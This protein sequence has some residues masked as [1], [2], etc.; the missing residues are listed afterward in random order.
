MP[1]AE[2]DD[3]DARL[4]TLLQEARRDAL[5]QDFEQAMIELARIEGWAV[6][7]MAVARAMQDMERR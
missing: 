5:W 2:W 6:V 1:V 7:L 3:D 4:V